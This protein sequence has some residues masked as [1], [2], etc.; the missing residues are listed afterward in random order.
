MCCMLSIRI[1]LTYRYRPNLMVHKGLLYGIQHYNF[2]VQLSDICFKINL[3]FLFLQLA[4]FRFRVIVVVRFGSHLWEF[5][6]IVYRLY[7]NIF[8]FLRR[9]FSQICPKCTFNLTIDNNLQVRFNDTC[10]FENYIFFLN[11]FVHI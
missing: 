6:W 2:C 7:D 4:Y 8:L 10:H 9:I 1:I 3:I 11:P 5:I